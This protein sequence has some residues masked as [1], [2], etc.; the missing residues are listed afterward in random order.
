MSCTSSL[1]LSSEIYHNVS[2]EPQL[3]PLTGWIFPVALANVE[4]GHCMFGCCC[5]WLFG[6]LLSDVKVFNPNTSFTD[7]PVYFHYITDWRRSKGNMN[8]TFVKWR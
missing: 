5:K 3:Q 4:D 7:V 2:V 1:L 6:V 8:S